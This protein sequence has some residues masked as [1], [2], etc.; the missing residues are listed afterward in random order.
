MLD[1]VWKT[2]IHN[3]V[4]K[5][6][7][8]CRI[9]R[10]P[11]RLKILYHHENDALDCIH[12]HQLFFTVNFHQVMVK[13]HGKF[14]LLSTTKTSTWTST[15]TPAQ[16][17]HTHDDNDD[18]GIISLVEELYISQQMFTIYGRARKHVT[19]HHMKVYVRFEHLPHQFVH[20]FN[21]FIRWWWSEHDK[22]TFKI[23]PRDV[24][25]LFWA[26]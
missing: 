22:Q 16:K 9:V 5:G 24:H 20:S 15:S 6:F 2:C 18:D 17:T 14:L 26:N 10:T 7:F 11:P 3:F 23:W 21:L 19:S 25:V 8:R 1:H 12:D 13:F 4:L